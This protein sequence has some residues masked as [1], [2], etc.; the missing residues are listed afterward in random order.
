[1]LNDVVNDPFSLDTVEDVRPLLSFVMFV[2]C[3]YE[4][5]PEIKT[6]VSLRTVCNCILVFA[7]YINEYLVVL[8]NVNI[9]DIFYRMT[10]Y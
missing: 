1:M 8:F 2:N 10:N 9:N 5:S 3:S 4:V 6:V 7:L